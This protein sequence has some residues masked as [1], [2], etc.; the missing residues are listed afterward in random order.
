[1]GNELWITMTYRENMTDRVQARKD[2]DKFLKRFKYHCRKTW[3][4][5]RGHLEY[6]KAVEPQERGAW[7]F[8]MLVKFPL[9]KKVYIDNDTYAKIW[10]HG[11]TKDKTSRIKRIIWDLL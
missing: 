10:K 9:M 4:K 7:H 2:F 6:V 5:T 11:I 8:H 3:G 1:M